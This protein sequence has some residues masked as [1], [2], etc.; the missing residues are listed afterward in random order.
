MIGTP[1]E[2]DPRLAALGFLDHIGI[3]RFR[4][5]ASV[6]QMLGDRFRSERDQNADDNYSDPA[7]EGARQPWS[8]LER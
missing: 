7:D 3:S 6:A 2:P 4:G 5:I 1:N 8:G